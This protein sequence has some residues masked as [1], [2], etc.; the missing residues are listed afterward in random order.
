[1]SESCGGCCAPPPAADPRYRK[2]LWIALL[3]NAAMFV[4]EL[5]SGLGAGS[6][7]LL[8]D[9]V[10]FFGDAAN[11]G[12]SLF[13]LALAPIWRSRAAMIKGFSMGAYGIGVL[14]LAAFNWSREV[15]PDPATMGIIGLLALVANV[16]V[17]VMLYRFRSG[18]ANMESVWLCSRNDA[19][20][21]VA[22][23]LAAAG[24]FGT[25]QGWPDLIV[26]AIMA[27]LGLSAAFSVV[28]R[29]RAELRT[30]ASTLEPIR[31]QA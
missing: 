26:A 1:M 31:T 5:V 27:S 7:S 10:D 21:N 29:A 18:D 22:V 25:S 30:E 24:V 12:V 11:Y 13:V 3:V 4:V 15:V 9:A 23:L 17:A 8:A 14:G 2:V 20:G 6:V 28:R 19:I 16:G